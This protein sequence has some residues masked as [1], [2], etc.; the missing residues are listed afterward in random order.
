[1]ECSSDEEDFGA[2]LGGSGAAKDDEE[3]TLPRAAMNKMIKEK[4]P[5][6]RVANEARELILQCA[7]DFVHLV[8]SEAN[9]VC[10]KRHQKKTISPEH[11]L[12]GDC[13]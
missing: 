2:G 5:T 10:E 7:T 6:I 13:R 1:M 11:V 12:E 8:S 3:L 9:D 4:M